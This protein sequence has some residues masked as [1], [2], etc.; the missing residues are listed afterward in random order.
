DV[1]SSAAFPEPGTV[2]GSSSRMQPQSKTSH[3]YSVII[4]ETVDEGDPDYVNDF[5]TQKQ[6]WKFSP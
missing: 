1:D 2:S 4:P 3:P 6:V 5:A